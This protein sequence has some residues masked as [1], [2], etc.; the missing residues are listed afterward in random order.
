MPTI[1]EIKNK[2]NYKNLDKHVYIW[3]ENKLDIDN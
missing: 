3:D 2:E 1:I